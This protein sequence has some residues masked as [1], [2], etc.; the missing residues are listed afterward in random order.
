MAASA[1]AC[2]ASRVRRAADV[3]DGTDRDR[4]DEEGKQRKKVLSL[5]DGEHPHRWGEEVVQQHEPADSREECWK[6]TSH[7]RDSNHEQQKRQDVGGQ[8][9]I[10][11]DCEQQGGQYRQSDDAQDESGSA[12]AEAEP[13]GDDSAMAGLVLCQ[14][15]TGARSLRG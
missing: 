11:I 8:G 15:A 13:A 14:S 2:D 9:D 4:H 1:L 3:D 5:G 6:E 10:G 12:A 7:E